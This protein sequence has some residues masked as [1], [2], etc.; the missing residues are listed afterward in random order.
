MQRWICSAVWMGALLGGCAPQAESPVSV[1]GKVT[2]DDKPLAAG[3]ISF[4][5]LGEPPVVLDIKDG[6]FTGQVKPGKKRVEIRAYRA[7][8]RRRPN[9]ARVIRRRRQPRTI[10][11]APS[12]PTATSRRTSRRRGPMILRLR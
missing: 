6:A 7:A 5:V 12:T 9:R 1:H 4:V 8:K 3:K 11:H 10:C 2:L